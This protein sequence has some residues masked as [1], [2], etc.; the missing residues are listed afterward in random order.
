MKAANFIELITDV[1][2]TAI[3]FIIIIEPTKIQTI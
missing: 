2:I 3:T 1:I